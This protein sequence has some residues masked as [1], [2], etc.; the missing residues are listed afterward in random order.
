MTH[1]DAIFIAGIEDERR[2]ETRVLE[3]RIQSAVQNGYH[4]IEVHAHGQHGIGGRLW[5][6][7][8]KPVKVDV[9]GFPGQRIGSMGSPNTTIEVHGPAS[10]DVGWL[11]AG[12]N[13]VVH[14]DATNGVANAM[15]QG[16]IYVAGDIGARGMTMTKSNPRFDPP[17]LWV[18]GG[19][20]D[21]FAEFMAG[22]IAVVCGI[23]SNYRKN[24][25][26][27]HRPCVG[28][29]GG[30]IYFHGV[31]KSYSEADAKLVRITDDEWEWLRAGLKDFLETIGRGYLYEEL[32]I[33]RSAWQLI[34]ARHPSEKVRT[35]RFT[36]SQFRSDVW[37]KEIGRGGLIGDLVD[38]DRGV[39]PV[40]A[41]GEMRRFVPVW[42]NCKY[43]PPCQAACPTG[44]PV[45][46]RWA[47]IRNGDLDAAVNLALQYTPFPATVC[48]H[49][50]PNLCMEGCT[51]TRARMTPI[52]T[53]LLG[54]ASL[55]ASEPVARP[56]TGKKVAIIGGGPAG[57]SVAWQLWMKG[58]EPVIFDRAE[59]LGGKIRSAI[60][61]IR[62]PREVFEH[63]L[64]RVVNRVTRV[65]VEGDGVT[66]E[67]FM[68]IRQ[69]YEYTVIAVGA[70]NPRELR[71]KGYDR[72]VPALDFLRCAKED[73]YDLGDKVVV[74]GAGNVGC[75]VATE[76]YRLGA[77]EVTLVDVQKPASFGKEREAAQKAGARFMWPVTTEAI[78][79]KG[80]VLST[81]EVVP[82]DTVV[83]SIGDKPDLGFLPDT[84]DTS[85]G[86]IKV[87][88][89]Y[90]TTDM[91][92]FAIGDSVRPGLI[93][94]AIGAGRKVAESIDAAFTGAEESHDRLQVMDPARVRLEYYDPTVREFPDIRACSTAC[95]SCGD[96]RDCG[97][98]E[99]ICPQQAISRR[100][101]QEGGYEYVVD[102]ER[103][104]GCGFCAGACPCG[105]WSMK[106]N[107]PIV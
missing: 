54:K 34:T 50:C 45:Q 26:L 89:E 103:C 82:A 9:F 39:L 100:S 19:V 1:H 20:G 77:K 13:I 48:G 84:I 3:E 18:L 31:Q 97:L 55:T 7:D 16:R 12:A 101:L 61:F 62:I 24:H 69:R 6:S 21:S 85:G 66:E 27:G 72:A 81:G 79:R 91:N 33:D 40:I 36:M 14:G 80:V 43:M 60:P 106:E 73:T 17:E 58:H 28:M 71:I 74:I 44:I 35:R 51:R 53:A 2:I 42:E 65:R 41:S 23:G 78:T 90:R 30:R 64:R 59:D 102:G 105:I 25:I 93:T 76:A 70:D 92:V 29:V 38:G 15:A 11:N 46:K 104:I 57:L 99:S 83:V 87:N 95:A 98:C 52:D 32:I 22:G 75:D 88:E 49:L 94:D 63:E 10:D 56:P 68:D 5:N 4:R 67:L 47:H 86:F 37:E 96:C 8:G 107:D